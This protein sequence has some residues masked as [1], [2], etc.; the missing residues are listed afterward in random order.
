[1]IHAR[2]TPAIPCASARIGPPAGACG[3]SGS[4]RARERRGHRDGFTPVSG[5]AGWRPWLLPWPTSGLP[6]CRKIGPRR[7]RR[8]TGEWVGLRIDNCDQSGQTSITERSETDGDLARVG[9]R[10]FMRQLRVASCFSLSASIPGKLATVLSLLALSLCHEGRGSYAGSA[11]P[12][13]LSVTVDS[14]SYET[15]GSPADTL[16]TNTGYVLVSLSQ[17]ANQPTPSDQAG[18]QVFQPVGGGYSNPC[19]GQNIIKFPVP[20]AGQPV[21]QVQGMKFF[22]GRLTVSVGAAVEDQG[23]DFFHL[24]NLDTCAIDGVVNV[25]QPQPP[26]H[27]SRAPGTFDLAITPDGSYAFVANEYGNELNVP[28]LW[29]GTI[30]VVKIQRDW[31]GRFATGTTPV[32]VLNNTN[33]IYIRGGNTLPGVT[34][35]H[36]GKRLYVTSEV[37]EPGY[38]NPT[39]S[40]NS[41]LVT[42]QTCVQDDGPKY[43]GLLTIIDV[44]RAKKGFG[45]ASILQSIASACS[46]ARVVETADGQYIWVA[47]R[48]SNLV[49]AF[50]VNKLLYSPN[51]ALVGNW[52]SGGTAPVGMALFYRDQLL[53]VANSNRFTDG[54][55]GTTNVVILDVGNFLNPLGVTQ[56]AEIPSESIYSFPRGVT[57][58]P[59]GSTLYVANYGCQ[60]SDKVCPIGTTGVEVKGKLQVITTTV[61]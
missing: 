49:L 45:Q 38:E 52:N 56:V 60:T 19:S 51:N 40:N 3:R 58:G 1:M 4:C 55:T 17:S 54:I 25:Q 24:V 48:G 12:N 32:L 13:P 47:A 50:D 37:A 34:V 43:N 7:F 21:S 39:N 6:R 2:A 18:V 20:V 16:I 33:Y 46:P 59:D 61:E 9:E 42:G 8:A 23:V 30:G 26:I 14:H 44:D 36:D 31:F 57:L 41:T 27:D 29:A 35:S 22:P 15:L 53:A 11:A 5:R 28:V 10:K